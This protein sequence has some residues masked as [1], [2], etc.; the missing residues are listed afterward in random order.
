MMIEDWEA[1]QLYRRMRDKFGDEDVA[2]RKVRQRFLDEICAEDRDTHFYVG[3]VLGYGSWIIL[4]AFY[5]K[6]MR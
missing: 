6:K 4:G 1:G 3:T 5:P 2:C